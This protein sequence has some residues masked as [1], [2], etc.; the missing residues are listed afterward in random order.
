MTNHWQIQ[1]IRR[2]AWLLGL[3]LLLSLV[4]G[5]IGSQI[6][7]V[8][9]AN[10]VATNS[11]QLAGGIVNFSGSGFGASETLDAYT[12]GPDGKSLAIKYGA[13]DE[14][15][16]VFYSFNTAGCSV[17]RWYLTLRG[18][19]SKIDAVASFD[20]VGDLSQPT[21]TPGGTV[22][23]P[24]G[25]GSGSGPTPTPT[26]EPIPQGD[27]Q[28]TPNTDYAGQIFIITG[29]G[30]T[31]GETV[32]MWET[33]PNKVAGALPETK[34]DD[35][36]NITYNYQSHGPNAG[37]YAVTAH[38]RTSNVEKSA[39]MRVLA[40][41]NELPNLKLDPATG[42]E[43]TMINVYGY[44]FTPNE[45]YTYWATSPDGKVYEGVRF[46]TFK[47]GSLYFFYNLPTATPGRWAITV[48][49]LY[50]QK[51]AVAYFDYVKSQN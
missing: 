40:N 34:A 27:L 43:K 35:K 4:L 9:A 16:S 44:K 28:V 47:D 29:S 50:S 5:I 33:D 24:A 15:G 13:T 38:G 36:G 41:Q 42:D 19:S 14:N 8:S 37:I 39:F 45:V 20:V 6:K 23:P 31:P 1:K 17:G 11:P 49:G 7:I 48:Q 3:M 46:S 2:W 18:Q 21:P 32:V 25:P 51:Q 30:Y 22:P 12:T 10:L 26:P